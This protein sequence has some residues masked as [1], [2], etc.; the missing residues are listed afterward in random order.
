MEKEQKQR[1]MFLVVLAIVGIGLLI[2][3]NGKDTAVK[4]ASTMT[5]LSQN[6]SA[7][8]KDKIDRS[9][10]VSIIE[11]KLAY[12]LSK[13]QGAGEVTVQISVKSTGRKEYATDRQYTSRTTIEENSDSSQQTTEVQEQESVVQQNQNGAQHAL[14]V[15]ETSPEIIGVLIVASGA[16]NAVVQ[17]RLLHAAATMLQLPLHQVMVVP[18]EGA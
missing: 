6:S 18:G 3:G 10:E 13:V 2:V 12:T 9:D 16:V 11:Q 17:E 4:N 15:E 1:Y 7:I 5:E 8:I 14:L